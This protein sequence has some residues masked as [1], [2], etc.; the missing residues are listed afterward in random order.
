[1]GAVGKAA[2]FYVKRFRLR[3]TLQAAVIDF[4]DPAGARLAATVGRRVL[5]L[6]LALT[7]RP[8]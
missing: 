2:P 5:I 6:L 4:I 7:V 8:A 3:E 1:L